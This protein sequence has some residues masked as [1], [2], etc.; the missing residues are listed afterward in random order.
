MDHARFMEND[1]ISQNADRYRLDLH[2]IEAV[3][4]QVAQI[5]ALDELGDHIWPTI[6]QVRV[7]HAADDPSALEACG[8]GQFILENLCGADIFSA[9]E[10]LDE[11][12]RHLLPVRGQ[13]EIGPAL[14]SASKPPQKLIWSDRLGVLGAQGRANGH[15]FVSGCHHASNLKFRHRSA[16]GHPES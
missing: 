6:V 3:P 16:D 15:V 8:Q 12:D 7:Q 13:R 10:I 2:S 14:A 5:A 1:E 4:D 9:Q 11:L